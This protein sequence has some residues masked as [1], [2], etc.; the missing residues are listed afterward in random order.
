MWP[1][2]LSWLFTWEGRIQRLPYFLAGTIL[3]AIKYLMDRT[4]ATRF[5]ETWQLQNYVLPSLHFT[6]LDLGS[7]KSELYI[8]IWTIAIPF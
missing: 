4:V 7:G 1:K 8:L 3:V 6:V 5:G 2:S